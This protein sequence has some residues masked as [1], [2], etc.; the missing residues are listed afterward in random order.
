MEAHWEGAYTPRIFTRR[1]FNSSLM[2]NWLAWSLKDEEI[3]P[4]SGLG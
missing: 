4:L 2:R 1:K 3:C